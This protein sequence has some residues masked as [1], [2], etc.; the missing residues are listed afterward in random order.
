[1]ETPLVSI[2]DD[3]LSGNP[4]FYGTRVSVHN[5]ID[6]LSSGATI[7]AFLDDFPTVTREQV[8]AFL[9]EK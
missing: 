6:Y 2:S 9:E 8:V 7:E 5:L 1:M 3:I 4:V